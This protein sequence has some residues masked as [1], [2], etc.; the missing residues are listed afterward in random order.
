MTA[1]TFTVTRKGT[2]HGEV[3][4]SYSAIGPHPRAARF[5]KPGD[6]DPDDLGTARSGRITL[7]D[8][9]FTKVVTIE[10]KGDT[11]EEPDE[12][13][14]AFIYGLDNAVHD[15]SKWAAKGVIRN[16]D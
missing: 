12:S 10:V 1:L 13:L 8:G 15:G 14:W 5:P 11:N 3:S 9:E 4:A 2:G 7:G 6:A 16:G